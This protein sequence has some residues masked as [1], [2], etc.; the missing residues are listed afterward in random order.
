MNCT[1]CGRQIGDSARFCSHCGAAQVAAGEERRVVTVLFSDIVG[2]TALAEHMDPESVKH[3]IDR[4]FERLARDITNHGGVV[5]KVLGDGIIALFGAPVAHGDDAERAVRAG[6]AMQRTLGA[7]SSELDPPLRMRIGVNTGEVLVGTTSA[8]G[9]YTAMGDVM[10]SADRL[11]GM[12][13]AGQILVGEATRVATGESITYRSLGPLPARGRDE[14][15]SAWQAIEAVR[16]PGFHPE[17]GEVFV[18]RHNEMDLLLAQS[19]LAIDGHRAQLSVVF[20]EAGMG[21]SRLVKEASSQMESRYGARVL[22]GRCLPYGEAN[23]W[24]AAADLLRDLFELPF[25]LAQAD[26]ETAVAAALVERLGPEEP[27]IPRFTTALLHALGY[28]TE[29]RGGDRQ[30]NRSEVMLAFTTVLDAELA[31]RPIVLVL[32]DMHWAPE[33]VSLLVEHLLTELSRSRLVVVLTARWTGDDLLPRGRH[34]VSAIQLGPLDDASATDLVAQLA[35]DLPES[36]VAGLVDRAGGNPFF[37]AELVN[38]VVKDGDPFTGVDTAGFEV[39]P[40]QLPA[41]L[42]GIIA[43]RLDALHPDERALL[44][45][46]A[47]LG[48]TGPIDGLLTM[49]AAVRGASGIEADLAALVEKD[50]LEVDGRRYRFG[51]NLVRDVAYGR[52]TKSVRAQRHYGIAEYLEARVDGPLRNSTVVAIAEHYRAAATLASE[53][54]DVSGLEPSEVLGR[55]LVWLDQAGE[56][57]LDV[58]APLAAGRWYDF[59]IELA[60][61]A[62]AAVPFYFGRARARVEVHDIAGARADLERLEAV[63]GLAPTLVARAALVDGEASRKAGDFDRAAATLRDAAERMAVL[64]LPDQQALALRLWGMTEM[65]RGANALARQALEASRAVATDA[66]DRR[67]EAWALQTLAWHAFRLGRVVEAQSFVAEAVAIFTEIDDQGGLVWTKGVQAWVA[68][69]T[70]R[71]DDARALIETVLPETRRRGDPWAEAITLNLDALLDLW[72]GQAKQ[73]AEKARAARLL[74]ERLA[75]V[76]LVVEARAVEGRALVSIGHVDEGTALL[77]EA[78]SVADQ[79]DDRGSRRMAVVASVA[80]AARLGDADR[81]IRWAA[82]YDGLGDDASVVGESDLVVSLALALLQR[83]AVAEAE[84]QLSGDETT[85]AERFGHYASAV[86]ALV[87]VANDD[88][89]VAD[90]LIEVTEQGPST[91]LDR[92]YA[93]LARATIA[94]RQDDQAGVERSLA[95][96]RT[97]IEETDDQPSRLLIDLVEAICDRGSVEEA[98]ARLQALGVDPTGWLIAFRAAALGSAGV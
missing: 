2:F 45:D 90:R 56:R 63:P 66:G 35:A 43:A 44:E 49:A 40:A 95:A 64:D 69:H 60:S 73:A 38:L 17:Q 89:P 94:N 28:H 25:D 96:A 58:G 3:L 80:S 67:A 27:S 37:L 20:G 7:L 85:E 16:P 82:R 10:N 5:D 50:L 13:E 70:G 18:G 4:A 55:A 46:A 87:A 81:A 34:G 51:S 65:E 98:G 36:L 23:A 48:R 1:S 92:L 84:A 11:Q 52:L 86:G 72:T 32:S 91:Y 79:A 78:H 22:D 21:K 33:A 24:W 8:G 26:A 14:P 88:L 9:D 42:T 75:D 30:R 97:V 19:R 53:V 12:A 29:L 59:G 6:L 71:W 15:I 61:D 57:A 62:T 93:L 83:G 41:T 39:E 77:D 74:G 76:P 31:A 47:V 68:Y 54:A